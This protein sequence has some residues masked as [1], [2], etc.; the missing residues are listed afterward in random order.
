[1]IDKIADQHRVVAVQHIA[2]SQRTRAKP[3]VTER[4]VGRKTAA[5]HWPG[6]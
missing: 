2:G 1:M 4:M 6:A 3:L 5:Q